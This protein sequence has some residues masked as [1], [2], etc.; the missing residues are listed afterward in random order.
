M[1]E[2]IKE[3]ARHDKERERQVKSL[4]DRAAVQVSQQAQ[5]AYVIGNLGWDT[6]ADIREKRAWDIIDQ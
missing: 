1:E 4:E 3:W 6:D 5:V 2:K